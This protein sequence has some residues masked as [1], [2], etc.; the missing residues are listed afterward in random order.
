MTEKKYWRKFLQV[1]QILQKQVSEQT[2]K[3]SKLFFQVSR[4]KYQNGFF[5]QNRALFRQQES[6]GSSPPQL[7][8]EDTR[9]GKTTKS[10]RFLNFCCFLVVSFQVGK[11]KN[12]AKIYCVIYL[13][14]RST[15]SRCSL[16]LCFREK[17]KASLFV[18]RNAVSLT[19]FPK[20]YRCLDA[21]KHKWQEGSID[22]SFFM[23]SKS[24]RNWFSNKLSK[25][26]VGVF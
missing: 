22:V 12:C 20:L 6:V 16:F 8:L 9:W 23:F 14:Y 24:S 2:F 19:Q 7:D 3:I 11:H 5:C 4:A 26:Q 1:S 15:A 18:V 21:S 10:R 25:F 13:Q 17:N